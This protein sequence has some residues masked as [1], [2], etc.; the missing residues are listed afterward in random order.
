MKTQ[1]EIKAEI[2]K[3]KEMKPF[4]R[5]YSAFGDDNWKKIDIEIK[6]LEKQEDIS[7]FYDDPEDSSCA[8]WVWDWLNGDLAEDEG[9]P[10][11]NWA[12]LDSRNAK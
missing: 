5:H 6:V 1:E 8:V 2:E 7:D 9:S 11:S 4:V 12:V 10:S 3:L